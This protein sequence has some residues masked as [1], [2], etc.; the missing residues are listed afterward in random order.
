MQI[1]NLYR[2]DRE[3]RLFIFNEIEKIEVAIRS[4]IVNTACE[5]L[6]YNYQTDTSK[7]NIEITLR[8]SLN[9]VPTK[10]LRYK[11]L[12]LFP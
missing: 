3:L 4:I 8:L 7:T 11:S 9:V 6:F 10:K 5:H 1:L 12:S 2:F